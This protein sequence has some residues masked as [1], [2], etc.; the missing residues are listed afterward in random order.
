VLNDPLGEA[1]T[2]VSG[3][4]FAVIDAA[5][6]DYLQ[7]ELTLARLRFDPLYRDEI[8]APSI[9]SGPH[10]ITIRQDHDIAVVRSIIGDEAACVWWVWPD[11]PDAPEAM[12]RH[13]RGLNMVEIP[14][15][16]PDQDDEDARGSGFE[17]VLFR[18]ADP[19]V[20]MSILPILYEEQVARLFG[21]ARS[22]IVDAP[23]YGGLR[24]FDVPEG[25]PGQPR[26]MLRLH[27]QHYEALA[28][29][30]D[31]AATYTVI[32]GLEHSFPDYTAHFSD[33]DLYRLVRDSEYS[34]EALGLVSE[35]A[36][37]H[38]ACLCLLTNGEM[39]TIPGLQESVASADGSP[40]EVIE[41]TLLEM[42]RQFD[43]MGA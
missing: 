25:L 9:A 43:S 18:H 30:A 1:L 39:A 34:G 16:R 32:E 21:R 13:L 14:R 2:K 29:V 7:D 4:L 27:L 23:E 42:Q 28:E 24:T 15:D 20:V 22:V 36:Y 41:A 12:Y 8:D 6:R 19:N 5:K 11:E 26:G 33:D 37:F 17:T 31:D 3:R 10:L 35:E 40:D 38:W